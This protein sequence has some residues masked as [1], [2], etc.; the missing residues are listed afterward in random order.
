MNN[1]KSYHKVWRNEIILTSK[2]KCVNTNESSEMIEERVVIRFQPSFTIFDMEV[3]QVSLLRPLV[4]L[5]KMRN[6][7]DILSSNASLFAEDI[8]FVIGQSKNHKAILII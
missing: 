4:L 6:L 1:P 5:T 7:Q 2:R 3:P 8:S